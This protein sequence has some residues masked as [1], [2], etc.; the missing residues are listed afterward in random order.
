MKIPFL[1]PDEDARE[2]II[3]ISFRN[4]QVEFEDTDFGEIAAKTAGYSGA[5]LRELVRISQRRAFQEGHDEVLAED[6]HFAVEDYIPPGV[7]RSDEIRAMEL[8]AVTHTTS[9]SLLPDHYV[10]TL[11][12]GTI[13]EDLKDLEYRLGW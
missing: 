2:A 11:E 7:S 9:R 1:L 4:L 8:M 3:K 13:H 12:S 6:L 5:D 10:K